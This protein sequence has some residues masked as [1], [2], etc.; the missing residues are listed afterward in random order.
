MFKNDERYWDINLLNKWFAISSVIFLLSMIWTFI[1]DNDDEFKD[2]QKK[3]RQLE[4]EAT[5]KN[6]GEELAA[7]GDLKD[8]YEEELSKAQSDYDSY[9]D[10]IQSINDDLGKLRADFYNINLKYSEQKAK[11]DVIKFH[12]ETENAHYLE[13]KESHDSHHETDTKEKY[14]T[15]TEEL[16]KVKLDKENLEIEIEKREGILKDIKKTLKETQ[17][18]REKILKKVNISENKLN[19]LDRSKMSFMNKIGDIVRDLPILD[20]MNP[21]Y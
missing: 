5:Q 18:T 20:F 21:Y 13:N 16:N 8:E 2:Y 15:K 7:V 3:F 11:I 19:V 17:D 9:S 14:K 6:L 1:D 10:Q 12:L 4:I